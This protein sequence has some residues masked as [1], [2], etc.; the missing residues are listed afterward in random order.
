M[1]EKSQLRAKAKRLEPVMNIGKNGLTPGTID[2]LDREL[3]QRELVKIRLNKGALPAET[4]KGVR[5]ELGHELC[6]L[7]HATLVEQVGNVVVL[8]RKAHK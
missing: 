7:T 6:R 8:F 5:R 3:S 2:L 1:T 4:A